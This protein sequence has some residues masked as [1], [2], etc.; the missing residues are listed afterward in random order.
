M[1]NHRFQ[2]DNLTKQEWVALKRL[3]NN[4]D[5]IIEPADKSEATVILNR[6][7]YIKEAMRQLKK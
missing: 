5:I 7:D 1:Y 6:V 2:L 4:K 3:S